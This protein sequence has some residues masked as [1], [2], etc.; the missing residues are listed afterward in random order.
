M[1]LNSRGSKQLK[2]RLKGNVVKSAIQCQMRPCCVGTGKV[3]GIV[4]ADR[5]FQKLHGIILR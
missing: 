5:F 4:V 3:C 2:E 1:F